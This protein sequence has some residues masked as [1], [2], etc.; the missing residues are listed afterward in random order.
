[1]QAQEPQNPYLALWS[2]IEG[3]RPEELSEAIADRRAVRAQLM[4]GTIHLVSARDCLA[5]HPLTLPLLAR[6]FRTAFGRAVAGI[7]V[8]AVIEAGRAALAELPRS[9]AEL[10]PALGE[11]WPDTDPNALAQ[12]VTF[13]L[14][15]VQVPPRGLWR[16]R[17]QA[18]WALAEQWLGAPTPL[19]TPV[20]TSPRHHGHARRRRATAPRAADVPR[21]AGPRAARHPRRRPTGSRH[22]RP[23][24]LPPRVRQ[25]RALPRGPLARPRRPRS[26]RAVPGREPEGDDA[27]RRL[28]PRE[29]ARRGGARRRDARHRPLHPAPGRPGGHARR[30][31]R[32]GRGMLAFLTPDAGERRVVFT[33]QP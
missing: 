22:A 15:L 10:R 19:A 9:R 17:G 4:R 29:L 12:A 27:G 2:R 11:R 25:P 30:D 18:R 16:Q 3:F 14:P 32:G 8:D 13:N 23:A 24:A 33:P 26:G 21:R 5:I 20:P 7:D 6:V 1:M 31:R 28:L